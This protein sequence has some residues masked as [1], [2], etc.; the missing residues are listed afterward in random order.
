MKF[1]NWEFNLMFTK[2]IRIFKTTIE[3][4]TR[5][6]SHSI[7]A[8]VVMSLTLILITFFVLIVLGL[9]VIVSHFEAKPQVTAFFTDEATEAQIMEVEDQLMETGEVNTINYV[10]KEEALQRYKD[11][12]KDE[13]ILL[14]MV[15]SKI[16]P[17]SLE[18]SATD[19]VYL[20]HLAQVLEQEPLVEDVYFQQDVVQTLRS[21]TNAIRL[22]GVLV[23]GVFSIISILI[24]II[25][26]TTNIANRREEIEIMRLVGASSSYIRW[27]FTLE[28]ILY[29]CFSGI[30]AVGIV[31][32][33]LPQITPAVSNF[34]AGI[35]LFPVPKVIFLRL[36][37]AD[38][39][40]GS[41]MGITGSMIAIYK[42]LRR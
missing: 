18:I 14:E 12:N 31:Y 2:A 42:G 21:W 3:H 17:A 15:T 6:L 1:E 9:N 10:S 29:G 34:M 33:I 28:G 37:L 38:V 8:V 40:L 11:Q 26:I 19:I 5:N 13:P 36:L 24:V 27:P 23:V 30:L 4:F 35:P 25:T 7:A 20:G 41:F 39:I 16:L 32:L 22:G